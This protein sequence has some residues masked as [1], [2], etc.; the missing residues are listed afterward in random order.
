M[1]HQRTLWKTIWRLGKQSAIPFLISII[2]A[3]WVYW[4]KSDKAH[5]T[6]AIAAFGGAFFFCTWLTG[7]YFRAAKQLAD[8]ESFDKLS[9]GID[10]INTSIKQL[11][12]AVAVAPATASPQSSP[13]LLS[14]ARQLVRNGN[15]LA[16]LLQAGLAFEQ[17]IH[18]KARR[19]GLCRQQ[20]RSIPQMLQRIEEQ[21]GPDAHQELQTLWKFRNQIVHADPQASEALQLRPELLDYF[22]SGVKMLAQ[23]RDAF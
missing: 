4:N 20:F 6:D 8:S 9:A 12:A 18:A 23:D 7:Q 11:N 13:E 19:I 22:E 5:A 1:R 10:D 17:A 16:G 21:L 2:Y 14:Q 3:A 15:V